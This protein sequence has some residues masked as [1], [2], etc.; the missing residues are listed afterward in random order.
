MILADMKTLIFKGTVDEIDVGKIWEGMEAELKIGAI[1]DQK[2][3]GKVSRISPKARNRR[4]RP[5]LTSRS[6]SSA[7]ATSHPCR[8]LGQRRP[9]Y[10]QG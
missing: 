1:P 3:I 7:R 6:S 5:C 8:L 2:I 4:T 10:Q 9:R